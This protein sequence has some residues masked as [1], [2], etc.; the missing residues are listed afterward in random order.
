MLGKGL[1]LHY[2]P[3]TTAA[4]KASVFTEIM[5][6]GRREEEERGGIGRKEEE[7]RSGGRDVGF[8]FLCWREEK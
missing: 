2:R 7:D 8:S 1:A 5:A 3:T 4:D 6:E